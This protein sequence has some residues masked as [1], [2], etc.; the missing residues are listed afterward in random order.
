MAA[1]QLESGAVEALAA[2]LRGAVIQ[3][4]DPTYDDARA[5]YNAMVDKRPRLIARCIDVADVIASVN[6]GREHGLDTAIRC[7]GHN[8]PGLGSVD[9]GLVIDLSG[10]RSVRVDPEYKTALVGGGSLLGDV[11]H[12][13][14]AFGLATP[15]GIISTTG[16]GGLVLGGGVG[17]LT[18]TY[19]LSIDNILGADVVLADGS[20]HTVDESHEPDLFWAIRGA[21]AN[22]GVVTSVT[23]RLHERATV[24]AGPILYDLDHAAD[25]LRWYRDFIRQAPEQL[26]GFFAFL[27]VPPGPPFPEEL[28]LRKVAAVAWCYA[29]DAD[30]ANAALAEARAQPGILLDGVMEL[31]LPIWNSAFDGV[32]PAGDQ[33]YWRADFVREIPDAAVEK[34]VEFA[35]KMPTWKSTMHM[36]PID[37]AAHRAGPTDTPWGARDANW[38][39]VFVGVDPDPANAEAVKQ[40]ATEYWDALHPYSTGGAYL[41][42]VMEEGADRVRAS[43]GE[44]YDRLARIKAQVD[45]DNFFHVN[46]NIRPGA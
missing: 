1:T 12:A 8:G 33:W 37:G 31:P 43:Y 22:F 7:G 44:N 42:M 32:Y 6:F 16:V 18:R 30:G 19:G 11:D 45:P 36:Y 24:M 27:S 3:P 17:H 10:L 4:G 20:F 13:T 29:G 39:S 41:N 23:L 25:V 34:H 28:H 38:A 46:Q 15:A 9:D 40:W 2:S 26:N 5:L 35:A 14:H 21:A